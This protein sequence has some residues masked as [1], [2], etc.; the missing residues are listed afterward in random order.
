MHPSPR[1][2]GF[3]ARNLLLGVVFVTGACVLIVEVLATR[4]LSPFFGNSIFTFSSVIGVVLA[5]LSAG[6]YIG[7]R[8][9]DR[10]PREDLFYG[11]IA[12]GGLSVLLLAA[13]ARGLLPTWA[14][15]MPL[16]TGPLYSSL[17]LFIPP[18]FLLGL[19][20]PFAVRLQRERVPESGIGNLAGSVFFWSTLGSI[21]GSLGAGFVLI[22]NIGMHASLVGVSVVLLAIGGAGLARHGLPGRNKGTF[23]TLAA[24]VIVLSAS[25]SQLPKAD[26]RV[27]Y[28]EDG[29]Y[30]RITVLEDEFEGR[31]ATYLILDRSLSSAMYPDSDELVYEYTQYFQLVELYVPDVRRALVL[32]AGAYTIPRALLA[33]YPEAQ[34]DVV[35]IE[36]ALRG[37][38]ERFFRL[39]DDPRMRDFVEDGRR[40]LHDVDQRYDLIFADAYTSFFYLPPHLATREFFTLVRDKLSP[41]GIFLGNLAASLSRRQPSLFHSE[42]RTLRSVFPNSEVFATYSRLSMDGQILVMLGAN[43]DRSVDFCAPD[44]F[45][46]DNAFGPVPCAELVD[47]QRYISSRSTLFTDD[48]VPVEYYSAHLLAILDPPPGFSGAESAALLEQIRAYETKEELLAFVD[49]EL[50]GL[51]YRV[52]ENPGGEPL[53]LVARSRPQSPR[54]PSAAASIDEPAALAVLL[55]AARQLI[56]ENPTPAVDLYF[57]EGGIE[58]PVVDHRVPDVCSKRRCGARDLEAAGSK[59]IEALSESS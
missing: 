35:D 15:H 39:E 33:R 31:P 53:P 1:V 47:P 23:L 16:T 21:T 2:T 26:P 14:Y 51:G 43:G 49:A 40:F 9:A 32:G 12:A 10:H 57:V 54:R 5:A 45:P 46:P 41:G 7:G 17:I 42:M 36:P 3:L 50:R 58:D 22:P 59:L 20:S 19:L 4:I 13:L 55:E 6:Y 44:L 38:S 25:I 52:D 27:L 8:A 56:L 29:T 28:R 11:I 30:E 48:F 37:V 24:F 34:V 18:S